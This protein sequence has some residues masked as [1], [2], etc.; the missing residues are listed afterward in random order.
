MSGFSG[1]LL[2]EVFVFPTDERPPDLGKPRIGIKIKAEH[3][4]HP[5]PE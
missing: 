5:V 3:A 2:L 1:K 4:N